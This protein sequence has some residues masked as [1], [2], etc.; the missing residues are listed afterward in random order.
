MDKM[1]KDDS[2]NKIGRALD[3]LKRKLQRER[4]EAES[5][6]AHFTL[7]RDQVKPVEDS[8]RKKLDEELSAARKE[9]AAQKEA[10]NQLARQLAT[11]REN[12]SNAN[13][14]NGTEVQTLQQELNSARTQLQEQRQAAENLINQVAAERDECRTQLSEVEPRMQALEVELSASRQ[15]LSELQEKA[16]TIEQLTQERDESQAAIAEI[17]ARIQMLQ[18]ESEASQKLSRE[19]RE[20]TLEAIRNLESERDEYCAR[21]NEQETKEKELQE[22]LE[23]ARK[24]LQ[25]QAD[26][27]REGRESPISGPGNASLNGCAE[28][29]LTA[30]PLTLAL[31]SADMLSNSLRSAPETKEA[32]REIQ[33]SS[34]KLLALLRTADWKQ[35]AEDVPAADESQS[36]EQPD[37]PAGQFGEMTPA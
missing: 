4:E 21:L 1:E 9:L 35:P 2:T 31:M 3:E 15:Q 16:A 26:A 14:K 37:A 10:N 17:E 29:W 36:P 30:V 7:R 28:P 22:Q 25:E 19:Q 27:A 11:E 23:G 12:H 34:Q 33:A 32:V 20:L 8:R 24:Q 5:L 18:E 13:G 6:T